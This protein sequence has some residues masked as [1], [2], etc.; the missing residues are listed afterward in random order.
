MSNPEI[1]AWDVSAAKM[2]AE[3]SSVKAHF[4]AEFKDFSDEMRE[5]IATKYEERVKRIKDKYRE[6]AEAPIQGSREKFAKLLAQIKEE[7]ADKNEDAESK[8]DDDKT[9]KK[10]SETEIDAA[11]DTFE[12]DINPTSTETPA[13]AQ[14]KTENPEA[15]ATELAQAH[16]ALAEGDEIKQPSKVPFNF[17]MAVQKWFKDIVISIK[18]IFG[19]DVSDE[20]AQIEW[21]AWS[22]MKQKS[23]IVF[24][25]L[26]SYMKPSSIETLRDPKDGPKTK[27]ESLV[28][29]IES[30]GIPI[31]YARSCIKYIFTGD[32]EI[33]KKLPY[34]VKKE[35][36]M[37]LRGNY[38]I[39]SQND[40]TGTLVEK[41]PREKLDDIFQIEPWKTQEYI[42][43]A[44]QKELEDET[45]ARPPTAPNTTLPETEEPKES[46]DIEA[47]I[48]K[49]QGK[50]YSEDTE[51]KGL[52]LKKEGDKIIV[53][54]W[55][56]HAEVNVNADG[57][58]EYRS[59][60]WTAEDIMQ[61]MI[62]DT[63]IQSVPGDASSITLANKN[64]LTGKNSLTKGSFSL[65]E[66][67]SFTKNWNWQDLYNFVSGKDM[68]PAEREK[69]SGK[70]PTPISQVDIDAI[71][72]RTTDTAKN[73]ATLI[74]EIDSE[75]HE[76][77]IT[78]TD[79]DGKASK[80]SIFPLKDGKGFMVGNV[81]FPI[82][83]DA[84]KAANMRN[85][86]SWH[87]QN[88]NN[89]HNDGDTIEVLDYSWWNPFRMWQTDL[90]EDDTIPE[91]ITR[92]VN[93]NSEK[94]DTLPKIF[95]F[96]QW[97]TKAG[98]EGQYSTEKNRNT[99]ENDSKNN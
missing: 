69:M 9:E 36:L 26:S 57:E 59:I 81:T 33:L 68:A 6:K 52:Q 19:A 38:I 14:K 31:K 89:L 28:K 85:W 83:A 16:F 73:W 17:G 62:M 86:V 46:V 4:R 70:E 48:V 94:L 42:E 8:T 47:V 74:G 15:K 34:S 91:F 21:Y 1:L 56:I 45:L 67:P 77:T 39:K 27:E 58:L 82:F 65:T 97:A 72:A 49:Y 43:I 13:D 71:L 22:E 11:F 10:L 75:T 3:I 51:E 55:T 84:I 78:R 99:W 23:E 40:D 64:T 88:G 12:N 60:S 98:K 96:L 76:I 54:K 90:M 93:A 61:L 95:D 35:T 30:A 24:S 80:E 32:K 63:Y 66:I 87:A 37:A 5:K 2:E 92:G 18:K 25:A 50:K 41:T 7:H 44:Q 79:A 20:L 53:D 29:L